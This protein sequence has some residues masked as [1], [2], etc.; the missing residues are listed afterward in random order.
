MLLQ[1]VI[2]I[3][4]RLTKVMPTRNQLRTLIQPIRAVAVDAAKLGLHDAV[5]CGGRGS[6]R[7]VL[8][9]LVME[10]LSSPYLCPVAVSVS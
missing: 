10:Q 3:R 4:M 5:A 6:E 2:C 1:Q 7:K 8:L 9:L